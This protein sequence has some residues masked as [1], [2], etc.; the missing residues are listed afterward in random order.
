MVHIYGHNW[1]VRWGKKGEGRS[2]HVYSNCDRAELSLNGE[3]LGTMRRDSQDFPAAG[4]RWEVA[5]A[6]GPNHLRAVATKGEVT[7]QDEIYLTYQSEQWGKPVQL[8][9]S[10]KERKDSIVTVEAKL[11]DAEGV[12]CLDSAQTVRFSLAGAGSLIDNLGTARGSREVQLS[13]GRAEI[14]IT[15]KARCRIEAVPKGLPAASLDL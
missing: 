14:S 10:Q 8:K 1:P 5:F 15:R 7:V 9:L 12:L 2:V 6:S 3:S 11:L 13:N 4:L